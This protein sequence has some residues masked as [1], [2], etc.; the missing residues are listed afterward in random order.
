LGHFWGF[1][2]LL[3]LAALNLA[4]RN[5]VLGVSATFTTIAFDDSSLLWLKVT[6]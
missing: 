3:A 4:S 2:G 1:D 6:N 5:V